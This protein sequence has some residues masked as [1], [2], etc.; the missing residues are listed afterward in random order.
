MADGIVFLTADFTAPPG[1]QTTATVE[2]GLSATGPWVFL[3]NVTLLNQVG[4]YYDTSAPLDTPVWYRWTGVPAATIVQGPFTEVS[5]GT[6]LLKDPLR[7]WANSAFSFC[8]TMQ[9]ALNDLCTPSGP[10]L[11]WGPWGDA[12]RA[13]DA[14]LPELYGAE[15]PADV[16]G[17][18]KN[19]ESSFTF[20]SKTLAAR[21]Q[22]HALFTAGGPL[23][24]Q[25]PVAYGW[26]DC[27]VQPFDLSESWIHPD[28]RKPYRL[29]SASFRIVDRPIGPAQ[30]TACANWCAV[31]AA[32]PTYGALAA[33]GFT[34][35]QVAAGAAGGAGC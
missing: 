17:R 14:T 7:P 22:V 27:F 15:R 21:D 11:I 3:D 4:V 23:Q 32:Y 1:T 18:R 20:L 6:V 8:E 34:W 35:A 13:V 9:Q 31:S 28:Q 30:G 2:R 33:T 5:D 16:F 19:R 25:A 24:M 26:E 12:T 29:W 10:Q